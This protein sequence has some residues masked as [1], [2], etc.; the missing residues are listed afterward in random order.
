MK[1]VDINFFANGEYSNTTKLLNN[2]LVSHNHIP[3]LKKRVEVEIVKHVS[4]KN[5]KIDQKAGFHFFVS[6]NHFFWIPFHTLRFVQSLQ[7]DIVLVHGLLFPIQL[8]FL[9]WKLGKNV[10]II[11]KHHA[12]LPF[13]KYRKFLL[14]WADRYIDAYFFT[15]IGNASNW[16]VNGIIKD[17]SKI[18][19]IPDTLSEMQR[20][21][22]SKARQFLKIN[23]ETVFLWVGRLNAN[24]DPLTFLEAFKQYVSIHANAR[25]Y[26]IYQT[27]ELEKKIL[28]EVKDDIHLQK[29]VNMI[30]FVEYADLPI[31]YSAADYFVSS[32][33]SEGGST[34]LLEAM[35]CGCVPIVTAI[36]SALKITDNG[37]FGYHFTAGDHDDLF[38]ILNT[39]PAENHLSEQVLTHFYERFSVNAVADQIASVCKKLVNKK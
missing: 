21:D 18:F 27:N 24:K 6:K 30:G 4:N 22:K 20:V 8:I 14:Q 9:K 31:W 29:T 11:A 28:Q 7:P 39:L 10:K 15:S 32:S 34:A 25:L 23:S 19:E 12:E 1:L 38:R 33:K 17:R 36:P 35:S 37:R 13:I 2:Q 5:I 16:A 26:M 3:E